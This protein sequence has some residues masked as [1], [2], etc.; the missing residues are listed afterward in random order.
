MFEDANSGVA[1]AKAGGFIAIGVGNPLL[2]G[3]AD[4]YF[5]DLTEFR[6]EEYA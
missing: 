1:A 4:I 6:L 2:K 5:N 3:V